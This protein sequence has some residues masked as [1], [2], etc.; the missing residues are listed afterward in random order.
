MMQRDEEEQEEG[1]GA[2]TCA[3]VTD[4]PLCFCARR[5]AGSYSPV[6]HV[7]AAKWLSMAVW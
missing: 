6:R 3:L 7:A 5:N 1:V 4:G 2:R